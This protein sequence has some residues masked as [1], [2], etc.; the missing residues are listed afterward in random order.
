MYLVICYAIHDQK[1]TSVDKKD[2]YA[3]ALDFLVNLYTS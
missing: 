2:S 3:E 1:I